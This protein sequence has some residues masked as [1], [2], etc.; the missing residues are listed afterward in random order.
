[1]C[2]LDGKMWPKMPYGSEFACGQ[3]PTTKTRAGRATGSQKSSWTEEI[4]PEIVIF[5]TFLWPFGYKKMQKIVYIR[6]FALPDGNFQFWAASW[7][8]LG[9][10]AA[11][12]SQNFRK[13]ATTGP[14]KWQ[15][16]PIYSAPDRQTGLAREKWSEILQLPGGNFWAEPGQNISKISKMCWIL[17]E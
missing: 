2:V 11:A 5:V 17:L 1:M 3:P 13:M 8:A 15:K 12:Q 7:S 9:W 4:L 6:N 10:L 14:Q 16:L